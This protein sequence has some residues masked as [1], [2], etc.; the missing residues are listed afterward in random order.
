MFFCEGLC[1]VTVALFSKALGAHWENMVYL[2][3]P[4][5]KSALVIKHSFS[6]KIGAG[7]GEVC[8]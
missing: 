7:N 3:W 4:E 8:I 2:L 1:L 5:L 6:R